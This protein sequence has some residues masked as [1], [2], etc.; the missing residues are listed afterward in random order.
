VLAVVMLFTCCGIDLIARRIR[1]L[2]AVLS[3]GLLTAYAI[4][5][6]VLFPIE[7]TIQLR[8][9]DRVR[10]PLAKYLSHVVAPGQSVFSE[11]AGYIGYYGH[12]KLYDF[13]GLTS[14]TVTRTLTSLPSYE[15][16]LQSIWA[17][18]KP[19]WLVLRDF[20]ARRFKSSDP[21][22][23]RRYVA[24]RRY[25]VSKASSRLENFGVT[26]SSIDRDFTI[27]RRVDVR[28]YVASS[29]RR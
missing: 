2:A 28:P 29:A 3:V 4:Q 10:V 22:L 27:Y 18:L 19:D 15:H 21:A 8:I 26:Y 24:V 17:A 1:P 13:P 6:P 16:N 11:S 23:F 20:E 7:R 14:P 5:I 25:H 12:V 9:E